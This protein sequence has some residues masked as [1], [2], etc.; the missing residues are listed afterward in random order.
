MNWKPTNRWVAS[1]YEIVNSETRH[2][3]TQ[4]ESGYARRLYSGTPVLSFLN[5]LADRVWIYASFYDTDGAAQVD[6]SAE[7]GLDAR[8]SDQFRVAD[9][10]KIPFQL[11]GNATKGDVYQVWRGWFEIYASADV[12]PDAWMG[13]LSQQMS[14]VTAV[15]WDRPIALMKA[16][17]LRDDLEFP[18]FKGRPSENI[19]KK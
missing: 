17:I 7:G 3:S 15:Y 16:P 18:R 6:L 10:V 12:Y 14:D 1:Y 4:Y 19:A 9:S 2:P 8:T 11:L 13:Y 5:V